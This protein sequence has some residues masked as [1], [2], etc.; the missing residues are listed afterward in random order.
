[1]NIKSILIFLGINLSTII[2]TLIHLCVINSNIF[3][4]IFIVLRNYLTTYFLDYFN[5]KREKILYNNIRDVPVEQYIGEFKI[6]LIIASFIE[7]ITTN[8][9]LSIFNFSPIFNI[10][11]YVAFF[12]I[13]FLFEII[14]DFFHYWTHKI[15]HKIPWLY[16]ITHKIHH[17]HNYPISITTFYQDPIDLLIT[18]SLPQIITITILHLCG[19]YFNLTTF[20][21]ITTFKVF[22]EIFGHSGMKF[23]GSSFIQFVW[24]P[25]LLGIELTTRDHDFHHYNSKYNFSKRFKL[26]DIV[27][28]TYKNKTN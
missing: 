16:K 28:G 2:I 17:K 8:L 6:K 27:F 9:I 23:N 26:W 7:L 11:N 24:L 25:R 20:L 3:H 14:F 15:I 18:N 22:V 5:Q 4:Y 21:L 1:M 13:S 19:I 12:G 10:I